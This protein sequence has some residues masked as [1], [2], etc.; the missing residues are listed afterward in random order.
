M[1]VYSGSINRGHKHVTVQSGATT[2]KLLSLDV[3]APHFAWGFHGAGPDELSVAILHDYFEDKDTKFGGRIAKLYGQFT[4]D[5][6][7][8]LSRD[9]AWTMKE[10]RVEKWVNAHAPELTSE[11]SQG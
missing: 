11:R 9:R 8:T 7:S 10:E 2:T 1:K 4:E 3:F 6:T 5:V